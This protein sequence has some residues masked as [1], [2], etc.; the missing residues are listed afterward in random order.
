MKLETKL[1]LY[2]ILVIILVLIGLSMMMYPTNL[3]IVSAIIVKVLGLIST[4]IG[5]KIFAKHFN[6]RI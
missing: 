6:E 4:A 1:G 3:P 5:L 2:F